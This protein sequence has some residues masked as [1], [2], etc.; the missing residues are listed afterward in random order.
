MSHASPFI[1]KLAELDR[2][3]Q[4]VVAVTL[5]D[6]TGSTPQDVG[7]K[8]LVDGN[9]LVLGTIGGGRLER[10]AIERAQQILSQPAVAQ[11]TL[12]VEWNLQRDLGMTC[13]GA[14][15]LLLECYNLRR[16]Q[17]VVFGAGHVAQALIRCLLNLD[18]QITCVDPR[19]EWLS[20]LP[21]SPRLTVKCCSDLPQEAEQ[22][23]DDDFVVCMTMGHSID[24]PILQRIF[25]QGRRPAFLGVIGSQAKR[26]ELLRELK[27]AGIPADVAESFECPIGLPLGNNQPEEIAIS[28]VAQLMQR[29]DA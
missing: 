13:G 26:Q 2:T 25:Q 12:L 27:S 23:T 21:E 7:S 22:L 8:M 15:K 18:C 10:Q 11:S 1:Q 9:G 17:I 29:R 24:G 20:R 3:G 14:V 28:I 6:V 4:P 5:V 19:A 16:W